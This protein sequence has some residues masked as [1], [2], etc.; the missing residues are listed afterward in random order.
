M[1]QAPLASLNTVNHNPIVDLPCRAL[2]GSR[3][4][5]IL[6]AVAQPED[7]SEV[8][9]FEPL[10]LNKKF[11]PPLYTT[12]LLQRANLIL[13][14]RDIRV[15]RLEQSRI[16]KQTLQ[17]AKHCTYPNTHYPC[18]ATSVVD[19]QKPTAP[20]CVHEVLCKPGETS[21]SICQACRLGFAPW[22]KTRTPIRLTPASLNNVDDA[23]LLTGDT[24]L[25]GDVVDEAGKPVTRLTA[26][27]TQQ[28]AEW[29]EVFREARLPANSRD[30]NT[31]ALIG[32]VSSATGKAV[33]LGTGNY[34]HRNAAQVFEAKQQWKRRGRVKLMCKRCKD[35]FWDRK[36][37]IYCTENCRKRHHE[38]QTKESQ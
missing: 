16:T 14:T 1:Q 37:T 33:E 36:G 26:P 15:A 9:G 32:D 2:R 20:R 34:H 3:L 38:E 19:A 7:F 10:A 17:A 8:E 11:T 4:A 24:A 25:D 5:Q 31:V 35:V 18:L 30:R 13:I 23:D 6:G 27:N 21:S 12:A 28:L 29:N 22:E